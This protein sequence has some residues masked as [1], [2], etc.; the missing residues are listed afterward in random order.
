[1]AYTEVSERRPKDGAD[2][3]AQSF[4]H[5]AY[6]YIP[7]QLNRAYVNNPKKL[8]YRKRYQVTVMWLKGKAILLQAWTSP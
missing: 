4:T 7:L 5:S 2:D 1:M 6:Y 3:D 8:Y